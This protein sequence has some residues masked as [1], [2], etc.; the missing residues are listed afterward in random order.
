MT[1]FF[2]YY[3]R[4]IQVMLW[5]GLAMALMAMGAI[6]VE[7]IAAGYWFARRRRLEH[8]YEPFVRR[9]LDGDAAAEQ[10]LVAAPRRHRLIIAALLIVPLVD[11]RNPARI[12]RTRA[13]VQAM[14][15]VPVADAYARSW[16]WWRR[17]LAMH[18]FG[19]LQMKDRTAQ[20]V[21][22]LDDSNG[23]VRG[24]ALDALTDLSDPTSLKAIVVRLHDA[25]LH[26]G[27]RVEAL[28]AF[29]SDS[30]R[31][32]LDLANVDPMNRLNYARALALVGTAY[33]RPTLCRWTRDTRAAVRAAAFE[34]LAH[35]GLDDRAAALAIDALKSRDQ[36]VRAMAA[37]A[38]QGWT[39]AGDAASHLAEHL[40]DTWIVA[41]RAARSLQSM[42]PA[43]LTKLQEIATR[44]DLSGLLAQ[45]MLW[46][47]SAQC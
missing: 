38:L 31:F 7:R 8:R 36:S 46:E 20:V 44:P 47:Q 17:G 29:G 34:A 23:D 22:A 12:A 1:S 24:A 32:L 28:T 11:D 33:A 30:E 18:V 9:A 5:V 16:R 41:V 43:G 40:A 27:R 42:G 19:V 4:V 2:F 26:R 14:S 10:F 37:Q 25:S 3:T 35:V 21:A 39:G 15:I 45:Q 13:I 6:V